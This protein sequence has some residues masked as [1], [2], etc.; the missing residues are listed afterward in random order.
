VDLSLLIV[1]FI[2][3]WFEFRVRVTRQN[4]REYFTNWGNYHVKVIELLYY[5]LGFSVQM[6]GD[7]RSQAQFYSSSLS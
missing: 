6:I 7:P 2:T 4:A 1:C 5:C 3:V